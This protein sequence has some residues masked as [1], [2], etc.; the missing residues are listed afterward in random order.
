MLIPEGGECHARAG[1]PL[2]EWTHPSQSSITYGF[3]SMGAIPIPTSGGLGRNSTSLKHSIAWS[4]AQIG[5]A[6]A[7]RDQIQLYAAQV[8]SRPK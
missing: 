3:T 5:V 6:A 8:E 7:V 4:I 1:V 2:S